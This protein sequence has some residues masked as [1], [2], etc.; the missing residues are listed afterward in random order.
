[1]KS[2]ELDLESNSDSEMEKGKQIIDAEP[3]AIVATTHIQLEDLEEP[4]EG[5]HLF[6][7][8]MWVNGVLL[9]FIVDNGS[10]KNLIL[11][12]VVRRLKLS[13]TPHPQLYNISW[14]SHG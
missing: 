10:E 2:S 13:I 14:L 5:E 11:A 8:Q 12:E 4:K 6:H 3:S 9:H 7:S 1:M